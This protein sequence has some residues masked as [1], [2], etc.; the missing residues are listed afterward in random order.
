MKTIGILAVAL[1]ALSGLLTSTAVV[2][3]QRIVIAPAISE[4]ARALKASIVASRA[5]ENPAAEQL[6]YFYGGRGFEPLWI[7]EADDSWLVST[8]SESLRDTFVGAADLGLDPADYVLPEPRIS[9]AEDAVAYELAVTSTALRF[10]S[11]NYGGRL[12]PR[13]VSPNLDMP[14]LQPNYA[15]LLAIFSQDE[16]GAALAALAPQDPEFQALLGLL[17]EFKAPA[18]LAQIVAGKSIK[19]GETDDR[20]PILRQRLGHSPTTQSPTLYDETLVEAVRSFQTGAGLAPDGIIGNA[21][22][23]ALNR[24]GQITREQ[25]LV[26][27]EKWRWL[28]RER[29]D[30]RVEVNIPEYRLWV[31]RSGETV[32]ETRVVVGTPT[33]QTPVFYDLIRHVVVN[34]Y[35]NVPVSIARGEIGPQVRRDPGYLARREFELLNAGQVIDPW[36][37]D[38]ASVAP[39]SFPFAIR[40]KPGPKNALGQVKF[41]FPNKHD[42]YL[43]DTPEKSL[44]SRDLRAYSHGCVRVENPFEFAGALLANEP[45]LGKGEL[46]ASFGPKERWFNLE[47]KVPVYLTYLTLRVDADGTVRSFADIYG[48][49][50]EIAKAIAGAQS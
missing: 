22:R 20:V 19:P 42:V 2:A 26:N 49:D 17:R 43:H 8:R 50:E 4:T 21:T 44:F 3:A 15:D 45:G 14:R 46:I 23:E 47:V 24:A 32:H 38:W 12:E 5:A 35:W 25:I 9:S 39:G 41:L 1:F 6:Y 13:K 36:A 29:G 7:T 16:P 33:N 28:P 27:L 48:H 18:P 37:I 34:P 30:Y 10:G 31:R 11:D 40:Q